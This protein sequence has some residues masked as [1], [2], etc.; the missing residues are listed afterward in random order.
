MPYIRQERRTEFTE[1]YPET[2]GD[3]NYA[4]TLQLIRYIRQYGLSYQS[5]QEALGACREAEMEFRRRVLAPYEDSKIED[6][7]D[8]YPKDLLRGE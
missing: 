8:V 6:D 1:I 5:C 3:L 7:G 2:A 4:I